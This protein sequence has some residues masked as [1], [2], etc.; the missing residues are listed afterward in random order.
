MDKT[1]DWLRTN[2]AAQVDPDKMHKIFCQLVADARTAEIQAIIE[3]K[4]YQLSD[5]EKKELPFKL[6]ICKKNQLNYFEALGLAFSEKNE[7][8]RLPIFAYIEKGWLEAVKLNLKTFGAKYLDEDLIE[9]IKLTSKKENLQEKA[10][11][12]RIIEL[13]SSEMKNLL[14]Q[15]DDGNTLLHL[16]PVN[17]KN[18]FILKLFKNQKEKLL[19]GMFEL[20]NSRGQ[21]AFL[22]QLM[23]K[24]GI[25]QIIRLA[26]FLS[27]D[28]FQVLLTKLDNWCPGFFAKQVIGKGFGAH[29][30][31]YTKNRILACN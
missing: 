26:C 7:L 10:L 5:Q 12:Q 24:Q 20:K 17:S 29:L 16:L 28:Y 19:E 31:L 30:L 1:A 3:S 25:K 21:S 2:W 22:I 18:K 6:K 15:D 11:K 4:H 14:V 8:G 9:I 27:F 13:A 23:K